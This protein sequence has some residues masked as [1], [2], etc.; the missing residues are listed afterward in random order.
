LDEVDELN[1]VLAAVTLR[2]AHDQTEVR[3]GEALTGLTPLAGGT[4]QAHLL[5]ASHRDCGEL[6]LSR[7]SGLNRLSEFNFLV[8]GEQLVI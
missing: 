4:L 6:L 5:G 1:A 7:R 3:L 2:L 8:C